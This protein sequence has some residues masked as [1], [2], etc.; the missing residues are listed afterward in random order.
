M[1]ESIIQRE[2]GKLDAEITQLKLERVELRVEVKEIRDE[3]KEVVRILTQAQ[4]GWKTLVIIASIAAVVGGLI[5]TIIG[6]F[7]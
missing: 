7:I 5:A 4:G 3:L 6:Y 1:D 2:L